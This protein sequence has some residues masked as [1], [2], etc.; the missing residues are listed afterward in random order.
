MTRAAKPK[1][2]GNGLACASFG[3]SGDWLSLATVVPD[4]G[5]V[6]L[7]G[8]PPFEGEWRGD[9][10]AVRRYRSWM[11]RDKYAFLSIDAGH[12]TTSI[13]MDAPKGTRGVIQRL[14]LKAAASERPAGVSLRVAG[15]LARPAY[16]E[17][18]EVDPPTHLDTDT[19]L[20]AV[21]GTLLVSGEGMPVV[22][23]A[24]ERSGAFDAS[25]GRG[26]GLVEWQVM[27]RSVP[28]A[29]AWVEWP[30][31][32]AELR[33]DIAC[34]FDA[35]AAGGAVDAATIPTSD[36]A[37]VPVGPEL[38]GV[39]APDVTA[40]IPEAEHPLH[41]PP[42]LL[43]PL[44][45]VT[46]RAATYARD[47]TALRVAPGERTILTDHR[48]LPLS[49][50]RDAYW[51]ARLLLASWTRGS[52]RDDVDLVA[53]HLRWLFLR[54]ER[55]AGRWMR[56]HHADGSVKDPV[57]QADQQLYPL[58]ELTDFVLATGTVPA[59]PVGQTWSEA[60]MDAWRAAEEA[61]DPHLDLIATAENAA[62]DAV[63]EPYLLSDQVLLW[64]V[65][66]RLAETATTLGVT[67]GP[68]I[69]RAARSRRAVTTHFE[70]EG[71]L[72]P[73]WASAVDGKGGS[74][75]YVD[76]NEL[77]IALAPLWGFCRAR[78]R[79]WQGTMAFAFDE[80]NA[81]FVPGELSGLGSLHTPGTWPMGDIQRWVSAG[82][83]GHHVVAD[84]ALDRLVDV[85][86][87]DGMLPEAY[88]PG[89][90][91]AAV[92]HWFAM[93]GAALGVLILEHARSVT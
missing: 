65:A 81:A 20:K 25:A 60:V 31:D 50:T 3:P 90:S 71:P 78:D 49:W 89:G 22:I 46:K 61:I 57:F 24:W 13:R 30:E 54:C 47:C 79:R 68:F 15:R 40:A 29:M 32:A 53:D 1:D 86:F 42:R 73:Q 62:D 82:L 55:P 64:R 92:R 67:K 70:I 17:V 21:E 11:R 80:A 84:A 91:G 48:L 27:R 66:S 14:V 88:D 83:A 58:L 52:R 18:A 87:A 10:D 28:T 75:T 33:L 26:D 19:V 2:V 51:Q 44:R 56:S 76:A 74:A 7:T 41:V 9:A 63:G 43:K 72:G 5:F 8:M 36:V 16:A 35:Q 69:D 12:A 37:P 85:A 45:R 38:G 77:P 23:E 39:A 4:A 59:L 93:P 34:T 6:E